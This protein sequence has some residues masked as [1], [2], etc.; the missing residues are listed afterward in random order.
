MGHTDIE[1]QTDVT[2][3]LRW[4]NSIDA[5]NVG[6]SVD[7]GAVTLSGHVASCAEKWAAEKAAQRVKGV[8][9]VANELKVQLLRQGRPDDT[10]IALTL[11]QAMAAS[12][13]IPR[14][15]I[16]ATV[17]NGWVTL[18]GTVAW[19]YQRLTAARIARDA[20][21]VVVVTNL[22]RLLET[23]QAHEIERDI[24]A[25]VRR[26]ADLDAHALHVSVR[27]GRATLTGTA[28]SWSGVTA[29]RHV[30]AAAPGIQ[31]VRINVRVETPP[32]TV[33]VWPGN[34]TL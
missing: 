3:E 31:D 14:D 20:R 21:G 18:E 27:D 7:H 32:S 13:S 25:A 1:V 16:Q 30:A 24:R 10:D 33:G 34:S 11:S 5:A 29:A 6:V 8:T 26:R 22:V 15:S 9:R 23:E 17:R 28:T 2:E 19:D 12:I 4:Y